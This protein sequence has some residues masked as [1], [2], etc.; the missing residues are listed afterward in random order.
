M[1]RLSVYGSTQSGMSDSSGLGNE[2]LKGVKSE[3]TSD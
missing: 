3:V 2:I 1:N